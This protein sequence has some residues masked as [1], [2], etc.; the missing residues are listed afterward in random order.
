MKIL[1]IGCGSI[2]RRHARNARAIGAEVILCDINQVR[3]QEFGKEIGA[4]GY[5][6]NFEDAAKLSGCNMAIVATPSNFHIEPASALLNS[7]CHV[8]MEKP[9]CTS[10][11]EA[12]ALKQLIVDSGLVF[13]MAH[14]Y[15]FRE[16]WLEVKR[17][18][19]QNP[20]GSVYSAESIGGWYLPDWHIHEDYRFEYAAQNKLGGGVLLTNLSHMFD[21]V[22]W[23]FGDIERVTGSLMR[24]SSLHIDVD[25]SVMCTLLTSESIAVTLSEDFLC[26]CPRRSLRVNAEFGYFEVD[27]HR[28]TLSMWDA[29]KKRFDPDNPEYGINTQNCFKILEDGVLYDPNPEVSLLNVIGNDPYMTELEYFIKMVS[30]KQTVFDLDINAGIKVLQALQNSGLQNWMI[31]KMN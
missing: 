24:L 14:T 3:M 10:L 15:R 27:F 30:A 17:I 12:I 2:G 16:E 28:K 11:S 23:L 5:F 20:L 31:S 7:G 18:L 19:N 29:R 6:T 9:L 1:V 21:V 22:T 8:M 4:S 13:M 26:R 25:D